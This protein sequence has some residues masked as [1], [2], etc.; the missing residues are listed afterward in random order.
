MKLLTAPSRSRL[1]PR[2]T[3]RALALGFAALLPLVAQAQNPDEALQDEARK[4]AMSL[5][6]KLLAALQA[7]IKQSGPEGAIPVCRDLAPKMAAEAMEKTGWKIRRVSLKTRNEQRATPD[8]WERAALEEFER[9]AA[10]GTPAGELEKGE[11]VGNEYR[12]VKALPTQK[13]CL[14]CHGP[15]E[16]LS[17]AV[18]ET[19]AKYYP[20]DHGTGFSEGQIRGAVSVRK[21]L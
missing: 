9:R 20:N 16:S 12:Y 1:Q 6:P 21:P 7:E 19:L 3:Q 4:V 13:L 14:Q 8:A 11:R 2:M 5:P 10:A 18:R 17:P 15:V